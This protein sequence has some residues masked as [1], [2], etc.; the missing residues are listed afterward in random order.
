MQNSTKLEFFK[1][2]KNDYTPSSYLGLTNKLSERKELSK[3]LGWAITKLRVETGRYDQFSRDNR[4]C[5]ICASNQIEDETHFLIY[6][7][8]YSIL[9]NKFY[10]KIEHII[11]TSK[12]LSS[13]QAISELMTSSNHY[14]DLQLTKY[15]SSCFDL[16][17]ILPAFKANQCSLIA[18]S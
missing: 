9:G 13:L 1:T 7:N 16:C 11:L 17:N 14:I 3:N 15:I 8:Q 18:I 10:E 6:C 12:Q 2:F 4:L 5:P